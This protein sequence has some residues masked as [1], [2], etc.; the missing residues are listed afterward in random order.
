MTSINIS[1]QSPYH[2]QINNARY[3][4]STCNTTSGI[5]WLLSNHVPF[6]YPSGMQAEDFLTTITEREECY[7]FMKLVAP[8][9]FD[10][11]GKAKLPPR[12]IHACLAWAINKLAGKRVIQFRT[13][14]TYE[15]LVMG[16]ALGHGAILSG[17]FT[18]GG[19]IVCLVGVETEQ[20]L[21][22]LQSE[23]TVEV[24]A[25]KSWIVDDPY[26]DWH[27]DY[28]NHHGN[29]VRFTHAQINSLTKVVGENKKWAHIRV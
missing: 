12:Q 29:D 2:T 18:R 4:L 1:S 16:L 11:E 22:E 10:S 9:N 13:D 3:P 23:A 28:R 17:V 6:K 27:T 5:L 14:V 15:A 19:H 25:I 20:G 26:G 24:G 7:T 8:W 21:S